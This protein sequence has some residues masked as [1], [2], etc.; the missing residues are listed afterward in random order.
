[1][2]NARVGTKQNSYREFHADAHY[3]FARNKMRRELGTLLSGKISVVSVDD[4]AK[5]KV[6]VPAVSRYHQINRVFPEKDGPVLNDHNFRVPGYLI[7]ASEHMF[8]QDD[9]QID[10]SYHEIN[11]YTVEAL[12]GSE[13]DCR[14]LRTILRVT[15]LLSQ[16]PGAYSM[17]PKNVTY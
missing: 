6:G 7:S 10:L 5:V 2:I 15:Y 17:E 3:F 8:L 13:P 1:M 9:K 12:S 11:S 16:P 4:I 14:K